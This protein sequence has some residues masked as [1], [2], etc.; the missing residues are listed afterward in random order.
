MDRTIYY[1]SYLSNVGPVSIM[2][3]GAGYQVLVGAEKLG[4]YDNLEEAFTA[5]ITGE[6]LVPYSGGDLSELDLPGDL[7]A[8]QKKVFAI[9]G[10]LRPA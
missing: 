3:H 4:V 5:A 8:W 10:R 7:A 6:T 2:P 9:I 1:Y